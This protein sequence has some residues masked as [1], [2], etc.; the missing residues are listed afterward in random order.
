M[1]TWVIFLLAIFNCGQTCGETSLYDSETSDFN[2]ILTSCL[3]VFCLLCGVS[4]EAAINIQFAN[5]KNIQ[6]AKIMFFTPL[7]YKI[8]KLC[9]WFQKITHLLCGFRTKILTQQKSLHV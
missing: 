9:L 8:F 2:F 3:L 1:A 6:F 4:L 7:D 5:S